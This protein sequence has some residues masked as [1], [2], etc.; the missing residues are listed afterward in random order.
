ML[1]QHRSVVVIGD[2]S[3]I[4]SER[5]SERDR[6]G[7]STYQVGSGAAAGGWESRT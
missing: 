1:Y 2:S 5:G 4:R 6:K 7:R 3:F